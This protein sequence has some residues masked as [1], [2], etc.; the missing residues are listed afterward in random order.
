M[1]KRVI[2]NA[3]LF[4]LIC[5][6]GFIL[7]T[8]V[9]EP[10]KFQTVKEKK[11]QEIV[12]KLIQIKQA[13]ELYRDVTGKFAGSFK[14]LADTLTH[15][16]FA[17]VS[18]TGD[19]DDPNSVIEY[20]TTYTPAIDSVKAL[21]WDLANL[22]KVPNMDGLEFNIKADTASYQMTTVD[23]VEVGITYADFMGEFAD[24]KF[25]KY[26]NLYD[27]AKKIKFGSLSKPILTG[28][29]E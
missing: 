13:Q 11:E 4:L 16:N 21:G 8:T 19:P 26:D 2:F 28:S 1:K 29:W 12:N 9:Q 22:G 17:L 5:A 3:L 23:V 14:Q 18:V 20:D 27:P 15:G 10:I 6:L 25:K 7:F 24:K